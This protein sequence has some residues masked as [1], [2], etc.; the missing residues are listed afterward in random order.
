MRVPFQILCAR[1]VYTCFGLEPLVA[2]I[3]ETFADGGVAKPT[4]SCRK[5][6]GTDKSAHVTDGVRPDDVFNCGVLESPRSHLV[7]CVG[8]SAGSGKDI[9]SGGTL[10]NKHCDWVW[11]RGHETEWPA[12]QAVGAELL[13]RVIKVEWFE[14]WALG[15]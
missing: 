6:N 15:A 11:E 10:V 2:V 14:L 7:C 12:S 1:R 5:T 8:E 9:Y 4:T 13:K 3:L